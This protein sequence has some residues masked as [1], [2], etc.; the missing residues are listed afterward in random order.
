MA[1][2]LRSKSKLKAKSVKRGGVFAN[3]V[4]NRNERLAKKMKEHTAKQEEA[5]K[6]TEQE[7]GDAII[8]T[9]SEESDKKISTS[10]WRDSRKQIYKKKQ[11]KNKK[12][13]TMKF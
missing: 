11:I 7:D 1:K 9:T 6:S 4:D 13:K 10:G 3:F 2:S 5:K 12:S 8:T